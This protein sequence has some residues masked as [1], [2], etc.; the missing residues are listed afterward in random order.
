M[1]RL[2][3]VVLLALLFVPFLI[4]V[5]IEPAS[6]RVIGSGGLGRVLDPRTLNAHKCVTT[7][8]YWASFGNHGVAWYINSTQTATLT[9]L[10]VDSAGTTHSQSAASQTVTANQENV[11]LVLYPIHRSRI[12]LCNTTGSTATVSVDVDE[13]GTGRGGRL[14]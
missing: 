4:S 6:A 1:K 5:P 13:L 12:N 2:R 8:D 3:S 7:D 11:Q 14:P 9:V 10:R